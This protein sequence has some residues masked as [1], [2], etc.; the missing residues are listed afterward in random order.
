VNPTMISPRPATIAKT[1]AATI[2]NLR[3]R[4]P[5][6]AVFTDSLADAS[7]TAQARLSSTSVTRHEYELTEMTQVADAFKNKIVI[8]TGGAMG[9]GISLHGSNPKPPM[10]AMGHKRT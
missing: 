10:S 4:S 3:P 7:L 9:L 6:S 2:P 1:P 5:L 8:V